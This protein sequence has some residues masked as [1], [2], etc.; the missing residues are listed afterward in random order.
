MLTSGTTSRPL[1][2][3]RINSNTALI[4]N[5]KPEEARD[6]IMYPFPSFMGVTK[7]QNG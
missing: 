6:E 4:S 7:F 1:S 3:T 5:Y 2:I